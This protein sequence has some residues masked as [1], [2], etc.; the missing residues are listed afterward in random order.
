MICVGEEC[1]RERS[2]SV[3]DVI[4]PL[5]PSLSLVSV[6]LSAFTNAL[7]AYYYRDPTPHTGSTIHNHKDSFPT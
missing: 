2:V 1:L 5:L 6:S 3:L 4:L 7:H